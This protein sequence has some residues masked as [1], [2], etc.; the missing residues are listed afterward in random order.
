M[1]VC[2]RSAAVTKLGVGP[3][4]IL[5]EAPDASAMG[6]NDQERIASPQDKGTVQVCY[7][8]GAC[9][10]FHAHAF[11]FELVTKKQ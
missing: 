1:L 10:L 11:T 5:A 2:V 4:S 7:C 6:A 8:A 9:Y 3:P